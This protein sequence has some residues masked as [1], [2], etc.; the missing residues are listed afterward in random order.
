M[1][2]R[3][4]YIDGL[5][6][7][8]T[9]E[10]YSNQSQMAPEISYLEATSHDVDELNNILSKAKDYQALKREITVFVKGR[11]QLLKHVHDNPLQWIP[12]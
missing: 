6:T 12:G 11:Q 2:K 8:K 3:E 7:D 10:S 5:I 4:R 1:P 9:W